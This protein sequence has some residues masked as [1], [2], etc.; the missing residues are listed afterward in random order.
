MYHIDVDTTKRG[1]AK[2]PPDHRVH[3][4]TL[5]DVVEKMGPVCATAAKG[6]MFDDDYHD[7]LQ[8]VHD[9]AV[10][11]GAACPLAHV[12][13]GNEKAATAADVLKACLSKPQFPGGIREPGHVHIASGGDFRERS[14]L[15]KCLHEPQIARS[16][17]DL[18]RRR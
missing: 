3:W 6:R 8:K 16:G 18:Y 2:S 17:H 14:H 7:D 15:A 9:L 1:S 4:Q 11:R 10:K 5:H 13:V 12:R